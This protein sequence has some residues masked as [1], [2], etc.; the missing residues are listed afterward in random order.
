MDDVVL[1][2]QMHGSGAETVEALRA[3]GIREARDIA[4]LDPEELAR[5]TGLRP[6]AAR[7][8]WAEARRMLNDTAGAEEPTP[9]DLPTFGP[10]AVTTRTTPRVELKDVEAH[11]AGGNASEPRFEEQPD[12]PVE[13]EEGVNAEEASILRHARNAPAAASRTADPSRWLPSFWRF[14]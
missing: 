1:L 9:G 14:G 2:A 11:L 4:A 6:A 13:E 10:S 12:F 5:M 3:K 8:M 7:R